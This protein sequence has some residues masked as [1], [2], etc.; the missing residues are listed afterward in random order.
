VRYDIVARDGY[1]DAARSGL[2]LAGLLA[3][4]A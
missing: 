2:Q 4:A 1:F 3:A